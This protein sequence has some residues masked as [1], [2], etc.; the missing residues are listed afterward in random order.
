MTSFGVLL[1]SI[2]LQGITRMPSMDTSSKLIV[3]TIVE[4]GGSGSCQLYVVDVNEQMEVGF[5]RDAIEGGDEREVD[6]MTTG[7]NGDIV[8]VTTGGST[9]DPETL[10]IC[11]RSFSLFLSLSILS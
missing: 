4:G 3:S 9:S 1:S 7:P 2:N 5:L 8:S 11:G 10:Y 6:S